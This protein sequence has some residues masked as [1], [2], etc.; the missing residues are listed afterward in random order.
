MFLVG[1]LLLIVKYV[2]LV[3]LSGKATTLD[4]LRLTNC[5]T[6]VLYFAISSRFVVFVDWS[7]KSLIDFP[8]LLHLPPTWG[9]GVLGFW[10]FSVSLRSKSFFFCLGGLLRQGLGLGLWPGLD[11]NIGHIQ[12]V[13]WQSTSGIDVLHACFGTSEVL[14]GFFVTP[15]LGAN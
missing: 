14:F 7:R 13:F 12:G 6:S 3:P 4:G 2:W 10:G 1:D 15:R 5:P 9:F 11:N 8:I